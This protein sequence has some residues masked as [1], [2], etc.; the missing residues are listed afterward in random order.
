MGVAEVI[1]RPKSPPSNF[2]LEIRDGFLHGARRSGIGL[3]G[4]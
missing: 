3:V 1:I 2:F 4:Q